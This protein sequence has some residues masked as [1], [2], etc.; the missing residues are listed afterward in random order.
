MWGIPVDLIVLALA[1]L[2]DLAVGELSAR[3][4]PTV[5]I[6]RTVALT[7]KLAPKDG[8]AGVLAGGLLALLV[9]ALWVAAAYFAARGL[10]GV[11]SAAY[12]LAGAVLLKPTFAVKMLHQAAAQVRGL[13]A[14]G[15][16]GGA[17]QS[18]RSL[19]SRD[20][21]H[22]TS[23][24]A[25]SATV[26]SVSENM[27]DS[28]LGPWLFFALFGL[29]G[30][31]AYRVIN[32]LDSMIG[33]HGRY[34]N[35]GKASARLDDLIN[36]VPARLA[37][38]LLVIGSSFLPGQRA[39]SAWRIMWRDHARTESPNAGWAMSGMAGAL[40]VELEKM[41]PDSGYRLGDGTR[42]LEPQDITRAVQSMYL[43][44][45]IGLLVALGLTY[46]RNGV[47]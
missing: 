20:P 7:E 11:H 10:Q 15:D 34:E 45:A 19:V 2:L 17:R 4:H 35:L 21:S 22:L 3:F 9:A 8:P 32:T 12:L 46:L 31:V 33:Y 47:F 27:A 42:A 23:A 24:Q 41:S 14:S 18:L 16:I 43:V 26:E 40:G 39:S 38:L 37:G 36:L 13:L 5:W 6:G 29:P 25:T 30:A 28:V 1:V 44:A